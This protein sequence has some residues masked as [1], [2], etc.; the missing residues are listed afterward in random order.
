[1]IFDE[2]IVGGH[3]SAFPLGRVAKLLL[4]DGDGLRSQCHEHK[5]TSPMERNNRSSHVF[6]NTS[7]L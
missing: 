4:A 5:F 1:M 7:I 6:L 2:E 3:V